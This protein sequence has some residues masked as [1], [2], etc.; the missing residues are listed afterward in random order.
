[1]N[2]P[3]MITQRI[4]TGADNEQQAILDMQAP[5]DGADCNDGGNWQYVKTE[6]TTLSGWITIHFQKECEHPDIKW[7]LEPRR[8]CDSAGKCF[9]YSAGIMAQ[10][11]R[12]ET[13]FGFG[14]RI[15]RS[16]AGKRLQVYLSMNPWPLHTTGT[17]ED[18]N[19]QTQNNH[20][21]HD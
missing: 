2:K 11:I 8:L 1:M 7:E 18:L 12:C 17:P 6:P 10:C 14:P 15:D 9:G 19:L 4:T 16:I 20:D 13:F 21:L 3:I 5:D